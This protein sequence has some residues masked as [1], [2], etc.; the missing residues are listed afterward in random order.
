MDMMELSQ[1][2]RPLWGVWLMLLFVGILAWVLFGKK[3]REMDDHAHIPL[4]D[5][6][7]EK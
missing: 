4:R 7:E 3:K 6:E 1:S 2:F 5:D